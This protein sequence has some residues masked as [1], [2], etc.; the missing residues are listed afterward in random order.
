MC[1][2]LSEPDEATLALIQSIQEKRCAN[3]DS[4]GNDDHND[5]VRRSE[6]ASGHSMLAR[7]QL[8]ELVTLIKSNDQVCQVLKL[9]HYVYL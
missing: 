3:F 1:D 6:R 9:K 7:R 8:N 2:A 4:V 5:W